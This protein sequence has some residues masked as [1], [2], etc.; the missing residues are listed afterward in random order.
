[1]DDG[2]PTPSAPHNGAYKE[3]RAGASEER[4]STSEGGWTDEVA[5]KPRAS[6]VKHFD[7]L[8]FCYCASVRMPCKLNPHVNPCAAIALC[9]YPLDAP[10]AE[11]ICSPSPL[12]WCAHVTLSR[13]DQS[14]R[15][16]AAARCPWCSLEHLKHAQCLCAAPV[17][18]MQEVYRY[19]TTD[20][21]MGHWAALYRCLKRKTKFADQVTRHG[22]SCVAPEDPACVRAGP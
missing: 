12:A 15:R 14:I 16:R 18:Q 19:G 4:P 21:C 6:C 5:S 3:A 10:V 11:G 22:V 8:W 20:D 1:M 7:A 17:H 9:T 2:G 13:R